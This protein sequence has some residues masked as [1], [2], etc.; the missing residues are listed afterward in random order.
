MRLIDA[1]ALG[2]GYAN[3]LVFD[4]I[5]YAHGWNCAIEI[6]EKAPTIDAVPVIRC[7]NCKY[8]NLQAL[9][10]THDNFNGTIGMDGF[11]SYGERK[12]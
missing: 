5:D 2:I 11:C 12:E 7:K 6:L 10:C 9:A 3:P 1:D 8:Y 4:K